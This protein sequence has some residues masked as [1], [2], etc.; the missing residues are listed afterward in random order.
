MSDVVKCA[1]V[2][3]FNR[4]DLH[5]EK[6][7]RYEK[8]MAR[9]EWWEKRAKILDE[10]TMPSLMA[11]TRQDFTIWGMFLEHDIENAAPVFEVM[12]KYGAHCIIG[13][14]NETLFEGSDKVRKYYHD[15]C[16][17]LLMVHLDSDDM[18][19]RKTIE[20][21]MDVT[22]IP[23]RS[24][25][26]PRGFLYGVEEN[27]MAFFNAPKNPGPFLAMAFTNASLKD[28]ATWNKYRNYWKLNTYH[29]QLNKCPKT[30]KLMSRGFCYMI[31]GENV[32]TAWDNRHTA[33]KIERMI[34]DAD[35]Q[36][37]M[38]SLFSEEKKG[39][40]E[41]NRMRRLREK[42]NNSFEFW[43]S[44]YGNKKEWRTSTY[45]FL[46]QHFQLIKNRIVVDIGCGLADGIGMLSNKF[47]KT[48]W[49]GLDFH[50]PAI[51]VAR[52]KYPHILFKTSDLDNDPVPIADTIMIIQTLEHI[53]DPMAAVDKCLKNCKRL[54]ITIPS[55]AKKHDGHPSHFHK[56]EKGD[57][58]KYTPLL[59]KP[60]GKHR[61][62]VV[63]RGEL[64]ARMVKSHK[65]IQQSQM[66]IIQEPD[67]TDT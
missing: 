34:T 15:T 61:T 39:Y 48:K 47:P 55:L 49:I 46:L 25:Y 8:T 14:N 43:V 38:M 53:E 33:S 2:I 5:K 7:W 41:E 19:A 65:P 29:H 23:G 52:E 67:R 4:C 16:D 37:T 28:T 60:L 30:M 11:Q 40:G 31:H 64:D 32:I 44:I 9:S 12:K 42:S 63:M 10:F 24:V 6:P 54:V 58:D 62:L 56:F 1:V 59:V 50:E 21:M 3:P 66:S 35:E 13:P 27:K 22:M 51:N 45:D 57:F 36:D 17:Y 26:Y 20:E 18:Y